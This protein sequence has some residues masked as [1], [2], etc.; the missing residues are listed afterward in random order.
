MSGR[1]KSYKDYLKSL[2]VMQE[3]VVP[4]ARLDM[5]GAILFAKKK[6]VPVGELSREDKDRFIQYL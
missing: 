2:D 6:G 4:R 3:P 1:K 5:R